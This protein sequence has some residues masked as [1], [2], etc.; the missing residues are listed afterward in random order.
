MKNNQ[1]PLVTPRTTTQIISSL[2]SLFEAGEDSLNLDN[3]SDP[4]SE[5][6]ALTGYKAHDPNH[7]YHGDLPN[8][9]ND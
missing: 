7:D 2:A 3:C 4:E 9:I 5:L 8:E 1:S 6:L